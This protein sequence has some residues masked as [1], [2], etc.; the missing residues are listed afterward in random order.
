MLKADFHAHTNFVIK[1][2]SKIPPKQLIDLAIKYKYD[3]VAITEHASQSFWYKIKYYPDALKTY[4]H[5]KNYAK[6]KGILLIPGIETHVENKEIL[7]INFNQKIKKFTFDDLYKLKEENIVVIAPHP[8]Y[9]RKKCLGEKIVEHIKL[10]D[11]IEISHLYYNFINPNKKAIEIAK[12]YKKTLLANSD[13]HLPYHLNLQFS[14]LDCNKDKDSILETI[15]KNKVRVETKP[16]P[17]HLFIR[18]INWVITNNLKENTREI[19]RDVF[20][21]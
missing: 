15:R 5:I 13:A 16:M 2:D 11:A 21:D 7:L 4:N 12:K 6:K 9:G 19:I 18:D 20:K 10:F 1:C 8:F 17:L 14:L 3:V